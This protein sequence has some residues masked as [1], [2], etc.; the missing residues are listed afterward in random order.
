MSRI[1]QYLYYLSTHTYR[2]GVDISVTVCVLFCLFIRL[3][4][5]PARITLAA[6]NFARWFIGVLARNL[7]FWGT[8]LPQKPQMGRIGA[9]LAWRQFRYSCTPIHLLIS[10]LYKFFVC[11]LT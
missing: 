11:V 6:S 7:P 3:Q 10:P 1:C 8:L 2:Q 9:Y 4:I 5:S